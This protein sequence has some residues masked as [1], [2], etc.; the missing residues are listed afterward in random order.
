MIRNEW[1]K[2]RRNVFVEFLA[3]DDDFVTSSVE[4]FIWMCALVDL[5]IDELCLKYSDVELDKILSDNFKMLEKYIDFLQI[6]LTVG[7][8]GTMH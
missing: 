5:L 4:D 8:L 6:R 2:K 3:K 7:H 1:K